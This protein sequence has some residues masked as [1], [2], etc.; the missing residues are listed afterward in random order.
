MWSL[1]EEPGDVFPKN[2][3]TARTPFSIVQDDK[4]HQS[5]RQ[6]PN[7]FYISALKS[8]VLKQMRVFF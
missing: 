6:D 3:R 4:K 5:T 1:P 7:S 8:S 2:P